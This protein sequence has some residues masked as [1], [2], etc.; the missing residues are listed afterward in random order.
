MSLSAADVAAVA[1]R[2]D[3]REVAA[4]LPLTKKSLIAD[5]TTLRAAAGDAGLARAVAEA[6]AATRSAT[7]KLPGSLLSG[8]GA[9]LMDFDAA[10]QATAWPVAL[11]RARRL[12]AAVEAGVAGGI[13]DATCSIGT[14][15]AAIAQAA[16]TTAAPALLASDRDPARAAMARHNLA[17]AAP[18][19]AVA[20]ADALAPASRDAIL[21]ADPARRAGGRRITDPADLI[22][23]LPDLLAAAADRPMAVKCAPGLDFGDWAGEVAVTSVAGRVK[24]ACLYSPEL[25]RPGVTRSATLLGGPR[26][27]PEIIDDS[28]PDDCGVA[29][30]GR[31]LIDPDGAVVRAGL[32]RHYAAAHGLRQIDERIAH[33]TGDTIPPGATGFEILEEAP[34]KKL[35]QV[36][37]AHGAGSAEILVRGVDVDPD[38]LRTS[39]KLKGDRSMAVVIT[40][41]GAHGTAFVCAARQ[42]ANASSSR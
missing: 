25:A 18:A 15:V 38:R 33:L 41:I 23:P 27:E 26:E 17:G 14:E 39:L 29:A 3:L 4:E 6:E 24:E 12:L 5:H 42:G 10:Q 9:W 35:R 11:D 30:P 32:V 28:M 1:A 36:L 37:A 8:P 40:R 22:P 31:F 34:I 19:A 7:G 16:G 21:I 20:I 13:H 2:T